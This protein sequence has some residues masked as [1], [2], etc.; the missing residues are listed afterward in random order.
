MKTVLMQCNECKKT[1][2]AYVSRSIKSIMKFTSSCKTHGIIKDEE[3]WKERAKQAH[4][5]NLSDPRDM[6]E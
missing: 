3:Y 6:E 4:E 2:T 1:F 5:A